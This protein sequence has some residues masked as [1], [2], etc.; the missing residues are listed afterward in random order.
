MILLDQFNESY[1]SEKYLNWLNNKE[2]MQYSENRHTNHT[3]DSCREYY[4]SFNN[5]NNL[6]FAIL[7]KNNM[8]HVG[9]INAYIDTNNLTADIGILVGVSGKGYGFLGWEAFIKKLFSKY[10]IR[11][12][13]G[14]T[15]AVN[16]AMIKIFIKSGMDYEYSKK[17]TFIYKERYV[18]M[19]GYCIFNPRR[20]MPHNLK[21]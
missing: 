15:M 11:K 21:I 19:V 10:N 2:L 13:S 18:D 12:V 5:S 3:I 9:N 6:L 17:Q 7:D 14:G 8:D 20:V 16:K 1:I 4:Q